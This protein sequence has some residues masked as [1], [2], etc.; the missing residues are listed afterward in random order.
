MPVFACTVA[1]PFDAV[2]IASSIG[3]W[4]LGSVVSCRITAPSKVVGGGGPGL[5]LHP[6]KAKRRALNVIPNSASFERLH[7]A[8]ILNSTSNFMMSNW[9]GRYPKHGANLLA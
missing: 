5:G 6:F 7:A 3:I 1:V 8:L 4:P 2:I 9:L